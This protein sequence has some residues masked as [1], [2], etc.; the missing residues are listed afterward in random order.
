VDSSGEGRKVTGRE[1]AETARVSGY[2]EEESTPLSQ[3]MSNRRQSKLY[4][5][6]ANAHHGARLEL[7]TTRSGRSKLRIDGKTYVRP[8]ATPRFGHCLRGNAASGDSTAAAFLTIENL[9]ATQRG[10]DVAF[11]NP[12]FLLDNNKSA[13]FALPDRKCLVERLEVPEGWTMIVEGT[14]GSMTYRSVV[15]S[16]T[17]AQT[18]TA[19][20]FGFGLE[21]D[22]GEDV[23]SVGYG[24][25][26][27]KNEIRGMKESN[28]VGTVV[29]YSR[30]KTMALVFNGGEVALSDR[31]VDLIYRIE[32]LGPDDKEALDELI[33]TFG[34]HYPYAITFGANAKL[35]KS[36]SRKAYTRALKSDRSF[37]QN[38]SAGAYGVKLSATYGELN[39]T[40]S[41]SSDSFETEDATFVA[42]NGNGS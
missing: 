12:F 18:I 28:V 30:Q 37:K 25:Q 13:V 17:E 16:E 40:S 41:A 19:S 36:I 26:E 35:T 2:Q 9:R 3:A 8:A 11:Q 27:A 24:Y 21:A 38:A 4:T 31:F 15:T 5:A 1:T 23:A 6:Q 22:G 14:Q 32:R 34:T 29:A 42:V 39:G 20:N 10:Y 7:G 33:R